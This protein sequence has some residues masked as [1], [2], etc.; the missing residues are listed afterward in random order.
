MIVKILAIGNMFCNH[1]K[2][3]MRERHGYYCD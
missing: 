3:D 2:L 1:L